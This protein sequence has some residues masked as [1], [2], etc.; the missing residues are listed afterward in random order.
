MA[1]ENIL[2]S[3]DKLFFIDFLDSFIESTI[4]DYSKILQDITLGWSWRNER[5]TPY[6][7]NISI[8]NMITDR[9]G[10]KDLE[11]INRMLVINIFRIFPYIKS[12]KDKLFL[13]KCLEYLE[14]R[15]IS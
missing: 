9:I 10:E 12:E 8:M 5:F 2:V 13:Y 1:F 14:R 4:A 6:I 7:K 11:M 15:F 3:G